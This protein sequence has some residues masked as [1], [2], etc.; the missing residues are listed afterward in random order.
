MSQLWCGVWPPLPPAVYLRRP[1]EPL[2]FPLAEPGCRLFARARQG[3]WHGVRALGLGHGDQVLAPAYHH[4]SEIEALVRAGIEC[5]YHDLDESLEPRE[6]DLDRLLTPRVRALL[7]I[8]Y[9]GFP[10]DAPRWRRWC[11]DRGLLL[12]ES[13]AQAWLSSIDGRPV[14]SLGDLAVFCLY[15]TFGILEGAAAI[16]RAEMPDPGTDRGLG[17]MGFLR[18][19]GAWL[20]SRSPLFAAAATPL[21]DRLEPHSQELDFSLGDP[22]QA[23]W[24][25]IP[26]L[27]ARVSDPAAAARRRA[28]YRLL[29]DALPGRLAAPFDT[30]P[31]GASPFVFPLHV[32]R[33]AETLGRL[34]PTGLRALDFWT[35]PHPSLPEDG[36]PNASRRRGSI[37][38]LPVH[39]ELRPSDLDRIIAAVQDGRSARPTLSFE[40]LE[41]LDAARSDWTVLAER[42]GSIF[43]TWEWMSTWWRHFGGDRRLILTACRDQHRRRIAILPLCLTS[44]RSLRTLRFIG[45]GPA[46]QLGPVCAPADRGKAARGLLWTLQQPH[47]HWDVFLAETLPAQDGWLAVLG[48]SVRRRESSPVLDIEG[49]D[50]QGFVT[51]QSANFRQ[52]LRRR[53]RKL[54]REHELHFRL[55][56]DPA[57][58]DDDLESLFRLH[59]AR[60]THERSPA[61]TGA[62]RAFHR[63]FARLALE[64]GWLRLWIMDVDGE[65]VAAWHGFRFAGAESYYQAGRDPAWDGYSVGF[66]MLVH[67]I[68]AAMNDGMRE[69]RF[70]RGAEPYKARFTSY[71]PGLETI[72]VPRGLRGRAAV[73][74]E[75]AARA[76]P[77]SARDVLRDSLVDRRR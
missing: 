16:C 69:Y 27:V 66:V 57:R 10:Q 51:G 5:R 70:L 62:R 47:C 21:R 14:G 19:N 60:W 59:G 43:S 34:A 9:L 46:D 53:E 71:D 6:E 18:R 67:S 25:S 72:V 39:Q 37:V 38:G 4:G 56:D 20:A 3:M 77:A 45:H 23:P 55:A 35:T 61:F 74:A 7:L 32:E 31:E 2:P 41:D 42:S 63:E 58:I 13:A 49:L 33:R 12:I 64:R 76:L 73:G 15:K 36:F 26:G 28:N 17:G 68:R 1:P 40:R 48:G 52:Q 75:N 29:A 30:L 65:P 24:S 54:A 11:D 50:W 44:G 22:G 8:H